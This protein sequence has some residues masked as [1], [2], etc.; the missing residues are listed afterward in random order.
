MQV[1]VNYHYRFLA[2]S[3]SQHYVRYAVL[4]SRVTFP[5]PASQ[6]EYSAKRFGGRTEFSGG[7]AVEQGL[8]VR[9]SK[10]P[11]NNSGEN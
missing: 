2:A 5:R 10:S 11:A 7:S 8:H 6:S 1:D 9:A 4:R 3:P